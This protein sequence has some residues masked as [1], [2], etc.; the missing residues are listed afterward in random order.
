MAYSQRDSHF[1]FGFCCLIVT[2]FV[3]VEA[4]IISP[5]SAAEEFKVG[6]VDGWRQPDVNYTQ[7][8]GLWTAT[9]RFH[10]GDSLRELFSTIINSIFCVVSFGV[11][12]FIYWNRFRVHE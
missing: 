6:D 10:V 3:V 5:A 9:K 7:I 2:L 4:T 12:S 8:Y 11:I 1:G